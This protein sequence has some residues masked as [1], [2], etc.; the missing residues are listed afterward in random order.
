MFVGA[1]S[2]FDGTLGKLPDGVE[3]LTRPGKQ[4]D[5]VLFFTASSV[6]LRRRFAALARS[7]AP[8]GGLWIGWPKKSS[9]LAT[10]LTENVAREIGLDA[11][12]VDNKVCAIDDTWSGL[13]FV[14]RLKDRPE[15]D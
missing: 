9:G 6:E 12:L 4:M 10:D 1:P 13:R 11:G 5:V 8:A 3:I 2:G 7:L 14:I 15:A